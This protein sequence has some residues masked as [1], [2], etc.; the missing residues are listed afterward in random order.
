MNT[1]GYWI[2][3]RDSGLTPLTRSGGK[4]ID[5]FPYS[6]YQFIDKQ[7]QNPTHKY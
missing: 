6:L 7:L 1:S 4:I 2:Q 3:V 5:P